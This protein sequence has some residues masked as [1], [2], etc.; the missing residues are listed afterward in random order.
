MSFK[1]Y[2]GATV[3]VEGESPLAIT[4]LTPDTNVTAGTYKVAKV[5]GGVESEKVDVPAFKT[6]PVA[7]TGVK[8]APT[9]AT[10]VSGTAGERKT[11]MTMT[12]GNATN[13]NVTYS[14]APT[15]AGL[16]V[17]ADG[18]IKW[19]D[20]VA[21][22]TYTMTVKTV[23]GNFT[24][25]CVLTLTAPVVAVT[26]VTVAPKTVDGVTGT[27]GSQQLTAT[28]APVGATNKAVTYTVAPTTEGL[29][30]TN[31]GLLSWTDAVPDGTYTVTAK[32][33]DQSKTDTS[34]LTMATP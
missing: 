3:V 7:A 11:V 30:V 18:T 1:L 8:I 16:T 26:G 6:L 5:E 13:K 20:A 29:T 15:T 22:G 24:A 32:T 31:A 9:T 4:G 12:P 2:K 10:A 28:V 23:D 17:E 33:T 25:T 14:I 34:V 21:S 19:T 27:A